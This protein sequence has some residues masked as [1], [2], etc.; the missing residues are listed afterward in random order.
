MSVPRR[1][2]RIIQ[3]INSFDFSQLDDSDLSNIVSNFREELG[4]GRSP[5]DLLPQVFA[6]IREVIHRRLGIRPYD[7]QLMGALALYEGKIAEMGTGEG[8][9]VVAV[10]PASF[11]AL[12]GKK[13]HIA[14]VNDYL[15]LRDCMWMGR[16]ISSWG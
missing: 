13:V 8:K 11:W 9:T 16:R 3:E 14:T 4:T 7:V 2:V 1:Y 15:A 5:D 12:C 6:V 10:F